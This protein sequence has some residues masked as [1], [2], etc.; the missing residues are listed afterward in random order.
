[1][2]SHAEKKMGTAGDTGYQKLMETL[3]GQ[4]AR[5]DGSNPCGL[6]AQVIA[7]VNLARGKY[8][9]APVG[10]PEIREALGISGGV[11]TGALPSSSSG[12]RECTALL[13]SI[14]D[15]LNNI[16]AIES[17]ERPPLKLWRSK[18]GEPEKGPSR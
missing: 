11:P 8:G 18:L 6:L 9:L 2:M 17:G 14:E 16:L 13:Q 1:M 10:V 5:S 4:L 3:K 12:N 7:H 15:A